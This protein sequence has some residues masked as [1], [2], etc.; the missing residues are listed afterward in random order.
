[1]PCAMAKPITRVSALHKDR[2]QLSQADDVKTN[3]CRQLGCQENVRN[4]IRK[5]AKLLGAGFHCNCKPQQLSSI[6]LYARPRATTT[7]AKEVRS[8]H[9]LQ[10][11]GSWGDGEKLRVNFVSCRNPPCGH[12]SPTGQVG[13]SGRWL[14]T[15]S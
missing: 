7:M 1:M 15:S 2:R 14:A 12:A 9:H 6:F 8:A 4:D 11:V 13:P 5:H 10:H 3:V